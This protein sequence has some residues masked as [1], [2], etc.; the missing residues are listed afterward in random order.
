MKNSII[1]QKHD[2]NIEFFQ[3]KVTQNLPKISKYLCMPWR[4]SMNP[5]QHGPFKNRFMKIFTFYTFI[6]Y[7]KAIS[8]GRKND[9]A[10][11][12]TFLLIVQRTR[13]WLLAPTLG[14]SQLPLTT[15]LRDLTPLQPPWVL[16]LI[17]S[18]IDTSHRLHSQN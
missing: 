4:L 14:S 16:T 17:F 5:L 2:G 9:S 7:I 8:W 3:G 18:Y 6:L 11:K 13:V 15:A 10:F 12:S 1:L